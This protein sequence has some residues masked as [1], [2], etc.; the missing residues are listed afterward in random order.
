MEQIREP[1]MNNMRE[2][3]IRTPWPA[4]L[5]GSRPVTSDD[6]LGEIRTIAKPAALADVSMKTGA[7]E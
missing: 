1:A 6:S 2:S 3:P 7:H 4:W 5:R